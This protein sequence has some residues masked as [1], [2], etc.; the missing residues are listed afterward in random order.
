MI[1]GKGIKI[2]LVIVFLMVLIVAGGCQ[3]LEPSSGDP[4]WD[5]LL[6][7]VSGTQVDLVLWDQ[8]AETV[9]W[10]NTAVKRHLFDKYNVTLNVEVVEKKDFL[11]TIRSAKK[12]LETIG[13]V[14]LVW[15]N[16][17]SFQQLKTEQLLYGPFAN[18]VYNANMYLDPKG[19][20]TLYMDGVPIEGYALPFNQTQITYYYNEDMTYEPPETL[21]ALKQYLASAPGTFT[22]PEPEDP[23]GRAFIH[24]VI[25]A[26]TPAKAFVEQPLDDAA[27]KALV[28]PGLEYL[29]ALKGDLYM[30]GTAYP[31]TALQLSDLYA[32]SQVFMVMS[33]DYR[34]AHTLTGDAIYPGGTRPVYFD[35]P[36]TGSKDYLSIPY[37]SDN[38]SGAMVV[39]HAL[40]DIE[41]QTQKLASKTY[42]GLPVYDSQRID[43][44]VAA[45]IQKALSRKTIP[46]INK[47]LAYRS[48][49]IPSQYHAKIATWWREL[50]LQP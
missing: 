3:L 7:S 41:L 2:S 13:N 11:A 17:S 5:R 19:L 4:T 36:S 12:N 10:Y 15:L 6:S 16:A 18:Q 39:M 9:E 1:Q 35:L 40:L 24:G 30:Q 46:D 28:M 27:L 45:Q 23:V 33:H 37:N 42:Q 48:H 8:T 49:D 50:V 31:K 22:Y 47:V 25:L 20:E 34:H 43:G 38:K 26:F 32:E 14:D 29:K 44:Q 21:E